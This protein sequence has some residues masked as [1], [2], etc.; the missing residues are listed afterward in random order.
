MLDAT[1]E[2]IS[3]K[4]S[5]FGNQ[6]IQLEYNSGTPRF[7]VGN[8]TNSFVKFDG[9]DVTVSTRLLEISASNIEISSTEASMSLGNGNIELLGQEGINCCRYYK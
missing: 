1:N 2:S 8:G 5:T 3:I 6:G 7:Y 9:T 4:N